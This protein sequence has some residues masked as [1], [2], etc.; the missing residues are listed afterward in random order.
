MKN[1]FTLIKDS[2]T[3]FPIIN[4][5]QI[6]NEGQSNLLD[7]EGRNIE[8]YIRSRIELE[9]IF[10]DCDFEPKRWSNYRPLWYKYYNGKMLEDNSF[11]QLEKIKK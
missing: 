3:K 10:K 5:Y 8:Y 9:N 1:G 2:I 7:E 4:I 11:G 6:Q